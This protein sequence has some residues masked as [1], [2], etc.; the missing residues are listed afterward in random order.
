[1]RLTWDHFLAVCERCPAVRSER[2]LPDTADPLNA[3][4]AQARRERRRRLAQPGNERREHHQE[5]SLEF[6]RQATE[7]AIESRQ[8]L[9]RGHV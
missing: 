7:L 3:F 6:A 4:D 8:P 1:M 5:R 9:E 2:D